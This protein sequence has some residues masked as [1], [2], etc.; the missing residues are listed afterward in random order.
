[1]SLV[2]IALVV[3]FV[4]TLSEHNTLESQNVSSCNG[5]NPLLN[6]RILGR[7]VRLATARSYLSNIKKARLV[8][9]SSWPELALSLKKTCEGKKKVETLHGSF[10]SFEWLESEVLFKA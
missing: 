8:S 6:K 4:C 3:H 7:C 2:P 10:G 5:Q 9:R 1:M